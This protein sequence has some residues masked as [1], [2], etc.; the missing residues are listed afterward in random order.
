MKT[1]QVNE[2]LNFLGESIYVGIDVHKKQWNV[3][4][5]TAFKEHKTFVQPPEP[6]TLSRYLKEHFPNGSYY[7]VYEAG[8]C[9]FWC[10]HLDPLI[11]SKSIRD[12][13]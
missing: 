4:I 6:G 10:S 9:G 8:F 12:K 11:F 2:K 7:S 13:S 5:M 1:I 3:S